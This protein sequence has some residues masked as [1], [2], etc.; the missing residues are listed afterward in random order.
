MLRSRGQCHIDCHFDYRLPHA[1]DSLCHCF[2]RYFHEPLIYIFMPADRPLYFAGARLRTQP[3]P[4]HFRYATMAAEAATGFHEL[5]AIAA[6]YAGFRHYCQMIA[7]SAAAADVSLLAPTFRL[8]HCAAMAEL[9]CSSSDIS[10]QLSP[11][12][13]LLYGRQPL[14]F[15][16]T[17]VMI[18]LMIRCRQLLPPRRRHIF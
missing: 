13:P 3:E 18:T 5:A 4:R 6:S 14:M 8:L 1:A 12:S 11:F 7:I 9:R 2:R 17:A 15:I 10:R 16:A